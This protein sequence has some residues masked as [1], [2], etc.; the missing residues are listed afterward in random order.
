MFIV[1]GSYF[2][3]LGWIVVFICIWFFFL[4]CLIFILF[5]LWKFFIC[6]W[7][8]LIFFLMLGFISVRCVLSCFFRNSLEGDILVVVWG[9]ILY[10]NRKFVNWCFSDCCCFLIFLFFRVFFIICIFCLV[11]LLDCGWYGGMRV[12]FIL[13]WCVKLWNLWDVNCGL[14]LFIIFFGNLVDVNSIWSLLIVLVLVVDFIGMIF[15]YFE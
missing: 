7:F 11:N 4:N 12:C 10:F 9:V 13:F 1:L 8:F 3:F 14:L 2:Y 6:C 15:N 5:W